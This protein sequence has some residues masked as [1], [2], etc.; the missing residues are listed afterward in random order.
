MGSKGQMKNR[1]IQGYG[2][3]LFGW[4]AHALDFHLEVADSA[5]KTVTFRLGIPCLFYLHFG[6]SYTPGRLTRWLACGVEERAHYG[7][8]HE[9]EISLIHWR[10][11]LDMPGHKGGFERRWCWPDLYALESW[12]YH[13][14]TVKH[15]HGDC[16]T[17]KRNYRIYD[18]L[19]WW[20]P[21]HVTVT[22]E[23]ITCEEG[24]FNI[25]RHFKHYSLIDR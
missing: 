21:R 22:E 10:K 19:R 15:H 23:N 3:A 18:R 24:G 11:R 13:E 1:H 16:F 2:H 14:R 8:R 20:I 25:Q 7:I 9:G 6:L 5:N 17:Q 12:D 4:Y